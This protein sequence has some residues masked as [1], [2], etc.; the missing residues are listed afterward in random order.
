MLRTLPLERQKATPMASRLLIKRHSLVRV[1]ESIS[2]TRRP[3]LARTTPATWTCHYP[4]AFFFHS[5]PPSGLPVRRRRKRRHDVVVAKPKQDDDE[6]SDDDDTSDDRQALGL[7]HQPVTDPAA[8][9]TA[10]QA[11][12]VKVQAALEPMKAFNEEFIL[13]RGSEEMGDFLLLDLGPVLGQYTI[14]IDLEQHLL[15][16]RSPISGQVVYILSESTGG[17]CGEQDGHSFEG[18]LVRDLIRQCNGVPKF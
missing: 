18:L 8:F 14:Q 10:A 3:L 4:T 2:R 5:S 1:A 13:T 16:F 6:G 15:L 12:L 9:A 7:R 17:W 11:L